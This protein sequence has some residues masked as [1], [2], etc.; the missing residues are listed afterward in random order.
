MHMTARIED[1]A[2]V[3]EQL[4][5]L[6]DQ[7]TSLLHQRRHEDIRGLQVEKTELTHAYEGHLRGLR[8]RPENLQNIEADLLTRLKTSNIAFRKS[9][10]SNAL[11][12]KAA[13]EANSHVLRAVARAVSE[14]NA[15]GDGYKH[16][17][18]ALGKPASG[19]SIAIDQE[20]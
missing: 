5:V 19:I 11:A 8:E 10:Q 16:D 3:T 7:E 12:L 13:M 15:G 6:M 17:G 9:T 20:L 1:L 18:K 2:A 14:L 4:I